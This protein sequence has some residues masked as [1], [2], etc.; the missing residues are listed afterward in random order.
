MLLTA[1]Y[2][3]SEV[4]ERNLISRL[5]V[6]TAL[7]YLVLADLYNSPDLKSAALD[8]VVKN[9]KSMISMPEWKRNAAENPEI[10][11]EVTEALV[12]SSD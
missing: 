5:T 3:F 11:V 2:I 10:F 4:C 6:N 9:A 8:F 7:D 12:K 1:Y